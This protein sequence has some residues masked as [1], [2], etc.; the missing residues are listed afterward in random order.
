MPIATIAGD[1][2]AVDSN[3]F[4]GFPEFQKKVRIVFDNEIIIRFVL[5]PSPVGSHDLLGRP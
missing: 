5:E 3:G 2:L 1:R 4:F